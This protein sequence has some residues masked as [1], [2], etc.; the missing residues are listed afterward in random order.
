MAQ[1]QRTE[2]RSSVER[3]LLTDGPSFQ[4]WCELF[5]CCLKLCGGGWRSHNRLLRIC[6]IYCAQETIFYHTLPVVS[7]KA[8]MELRNWR[9]FGNGMLE[10]CW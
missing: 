2:C 1:G 5:C 9:P 7:R 10:G 8:N 4:A 3:A 6:G